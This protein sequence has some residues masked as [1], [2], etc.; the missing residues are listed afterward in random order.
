M[1][2]YLL[3]ILLVLTTALCAQEASTDRLERDLQVAS[4][5]LSTLLE[6][7]N[8][9]EHFGFFKKEVTARYVEGLG[10]IFSVPT[11]RFPS[12]AVRIVTN[13]EGGQDA[14]YI[15]KDRVEVRGLAKSS[16]TDLVVKDEQIEET[17]K[18]FLRD[19]G[20]LLSTLSPSD[21]ILIRSNE[22]DSYGNHY[23]KMVGEKAAWRKKGTR[24]QLQMGV[25]MKD[26]MAFDEGR[27]SEEEFDSRITVTREA[28]ESKDDPELDVFG[29]ILYR[30]FSAD[31]SDTYYMDSDPWHESFNDFGVTYHVKVY[32]SSSEGYEHYITTLDKGGLTQSERNEIVNGM[33][34]SFV[35]AFKEN[36]LDY[37]HTLRN[38]EDDEVINFSINLT[39]CSGCE[40]PKEIEL[41]VKK[42]TLSKYRSKELTLQ[43][44][45]DQFTL[46]VLK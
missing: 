46:S 25:A 3:A 18:L 1:K 27:L 26:V 44:A 28:S 11:A 43:Q 2:F 20:N 33:Y 41:S 36:V 10:A 34:P 4:E 32:S 12:G 21:R 6:Q 19:Y 9:D 17:V 23:L 37:G 24:P 7:D 42:G 40:M 16:S 31:I 5:V 30:V 14:I 35:S 22:G 8:D 39:E 45:K 13:E 15:D 38:L 29:S